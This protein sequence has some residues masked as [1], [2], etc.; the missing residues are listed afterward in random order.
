MNRTLGFLDSGEVAAAASTLGIMHPTGYP[1]L[2]MLAHLVT[3]VAPVRDILALNVLAALMTGAGIGVLTLLFDQL[4]NVV[5]A[6]RRT[7]RATPAPSS[8]RA[9]KRASRGAGRD[10]RSESDAITAA[11]AIAPLDAKQSLTRPVVA[12]LA[13]LHVGFTA[14]WWAQASGF[15]VYALQALLLPLVT[16]LFVRFVDR[17]RAR[18]SIGS[19]VRLTWDASLFAIVLGLAFTNHLMTIFLAPAFLVYY[20][21]SLGVGARSLGR[22]LL[23][24]PPFVAGLLPYLY[25]P[26]RSSMRPRFNWGRPDTWERFVDHV[27]GKFAWEWMFSSE[28]IYR[29]Q[30]EYFFDRLPSEL[31]YV[32]LALAVAGLV[33]LAV[34]SP[35]LAVWSA[36]IFIG[37]VGYA[38]G[39]RIYDV[40]LYYP[41]AILATG[42]WI[43]A[44]LAWILGRKP[45]AAII[46]GAALAVANLALHYS[47]LDQSDNTIAEDFVHN[48]LVTAPKNAMIFSSNAAV[49]V[50]GSYYLQ[51]VERLRPDVIVINHDYLSNR[52]YVEELRDWRP[53]MMRAVDTVVNRYQELLDR[54]DSGDVRAGLASV[55]AFGKIVRGLVEWQRSR[56]AETMVLG[57]LDP[58][59]ERFGLVPYQLGYLLRSD[60]AYV[61]Q[62]FPTYRFRH[63]T[64]ID[65]FAANIYELYGRGLAYRASYEAEHG[66]DSLAARYREHALTFDPRYDL[67]NAP[68]LALDAMSQVI[69]TS[70]F[71]ARLRQS[72]APR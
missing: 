34:R 52:W 65:P 40:E 55:D 53:E 69:A 49:F 31:A 61:Q 8:K 46:V 60:T 72:S 43:T 62:P 9:A 56:G 24:I 22:L 12:A 10:A 29:S 30:T 7:P 19:P 71:Y 36:L 50:T 13:A 70:E 44:A 23:L 35:R 21:W 45:V 26:L 3:L 17:E 64:R 18:R 1:T 6:P 4:M 66:R 27:S 20:F 39:Y 58:A 14:V 48:V 28:E 59:F 51:E 15:E 32:G 33:V 47:S 37:C 25:L 54:A 38:G 57:A 16:L 11:R 2:T 67:E 5:L 42:I 63:W 41:T 68:R